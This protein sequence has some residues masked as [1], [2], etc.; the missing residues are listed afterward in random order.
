MPQQTRIGGGLAQ[1]QA[2]PPS[3]SLGAIEDRLTE[4]G[5]DGIEF[6]ARGRDWVAT[7]FIGS[8]RAQAIGPSRLRAAQE[9]V[10]VVTRP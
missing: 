2:R 7:S 10:R 4:L 5:Y 9:L 3:H 6:E 8:Y 1:V